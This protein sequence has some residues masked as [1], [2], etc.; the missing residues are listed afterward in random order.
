MGEIMIFND[1]ATSI[2]DRLGT[3]GVTIVNAFDHFEILLP[4]IYSPPECAISV[5][6]EDPS[7]LKASPDLNFCVI[8]KSTILFVWQ[9]TKMTMYSFTPLRWLRELW[10]VVI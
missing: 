8:S 10:N 1:I 5:P 9:S 4:A 2:V 3:F 6:F 7:E